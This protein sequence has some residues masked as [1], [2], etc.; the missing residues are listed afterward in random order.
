MSLHD[1]CDIALQKLSLSFDI[2][3]HDESLFLFLHSESS[4][5]LDPS[6]DRKL[7]SPI[8][9]LSLFTLFF[10]TRA[11]YYSYIKKTY[12]YI[13][14]VR[15]LCTSRQSRNVSFWSCSCADK[16]WSQIDKN[17]V[18]R[19]KYWMRQS[20]PAKALKVHEKYRPNANKNSVKSQKSPESFRNATF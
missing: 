20:T 3:E 10:C 4:S 14:N 7:A 2:C 18:K 8:A 12:K 6:S 5:L 19:R 1:L 17:G 11:L 16:K 13:F 9:T 15:T